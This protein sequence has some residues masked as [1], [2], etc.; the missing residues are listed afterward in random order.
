MSG[1]VLASSR[2]D[3]ANA[4]LVIVDVLTDYRFPDGA[5]LRR[6]AIPALRNLS[7]LRRR[8][9]GHDIPVVYANDNR[10]RWRSDMR[11]VIARC[12][13][14]LADGLAPESDDYLVLK[15]KQS[16]FY[17]TPLAEL[18]HD[19]GSRLIVLAGIAGDGCVLCTA[20]DAHLRGYRVVVPRDCVA[21][22]SGARNRRALDILD[23]SFGIDTRTG[24]RI[25]RN[26]L[27]RGS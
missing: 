12:M 16:A 20:I 2:Q 11:E 27:A 22:L 9:R 24:R 23:E 26:L 6:Q 10:G 8:L 13:P 19:L 3:R 5:R 1:K 17:A 4:V 7:A 14:M 21:S 15:P 18:L 25:D